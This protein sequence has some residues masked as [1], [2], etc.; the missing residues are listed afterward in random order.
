MKR[1]Y[2]KLA[3]CHSRGNLNIAHGRPVHAILVCVREYYMLCFMI[4]L[5]LKRP[6]FG[7]Y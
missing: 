3:I 6:L 4:M 5:P 2:F 1:L 7:A